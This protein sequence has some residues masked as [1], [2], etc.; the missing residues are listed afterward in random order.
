MTLVSSQTDREGAASVIFERLLSDP[1]H[2]PRIRSI[3][4]VC[5]ASLQW[6]KYPIK[7]RTMKKIDGA[8]RIPDSLLIRK[9]R[10]VQVPVITCHTSIDSTL[11]YNDCVCISHYDTAFI[12]A[13][14]I[15]VPKIS[16][17]Y[18]SNGEKFKQLVRS[19]S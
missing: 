15:N 18:G 6:A 8:L 1:T 3:E 17:C 16:V 4:H 7:D 12:K 9:L 2:A 11:K 19:S 14:G 10:D 13:G 5:D